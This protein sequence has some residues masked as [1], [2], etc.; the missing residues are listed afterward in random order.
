MAHRI[1]LLVA[2]TILS[3]AESA[4]ACFMQQGSPSSWV[5]DADIIVRARVWR[6]NEA[7]AAPSPPWVETSI[8]LGVAEVLKGEVQ[9]TVDV[10]GT[11]ANH[12]D[13]NNLPV[14]YGMVRPGGRGGGCFARSYQRDGEY[15]LLL[16][17]VLGKLTPYWASL[18]AT[19]E[20]I[21]GADDPWVA[22]VRQQLASTPETSTSNW[23][24]PK[25]R[26]LGPPAS[27]Y[28]ASAFLYRSR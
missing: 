20:Q 12:S 11:L 16:K 6:L 2:A 3:G 28:S 22:W 9:F 27:L 23:L 18:G 26:Q 17:K 24:A 1:A 14:P 21:R 8:R 19:N 7:P 25:R 13:M 15:L 5:S 4:F 10:S